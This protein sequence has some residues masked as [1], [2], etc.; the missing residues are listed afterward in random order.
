MDLEDDIVTNYVYRLALF[1]RKMLAD[2]KIYFVS[3]GTQY[4]FKSE[5]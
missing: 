5:M 1:A 2:M 3:G 4:V